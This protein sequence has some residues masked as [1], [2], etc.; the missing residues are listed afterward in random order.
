MTETEETDTATPTVDEEAVPVDDNVQGGDTKQERR[1]GFVVDCAADPQSQRTWN[2]QRILYAVAGCTSSCIVLAVRLVLDSTPLAYL[3]HSVIVFLDMVLIH[4]F[5]H[6]LWLSVAGELTTYACFLAFHYTKGTI[7]ELLETTFIAVW[8]SFNLLASRSKAM[9]R[10]RALQADVQTLKHNLQKVVAEED[11]REHELASSG[12][13]FIALNNP[14]CK[15]RFMTC[16]EQFFEEFLDGSA[17]V[18]YTSFLGLILT[19]L[20]RYASGQ[21]KSY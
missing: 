21:Q 8:C 15:K 9:E 1:P 2:K 14:E 20:I 12:K 19:E 16:G 17:G 5:T 13:I 7:F 10:N 11:E 18:M 4:I 3:I 6:S